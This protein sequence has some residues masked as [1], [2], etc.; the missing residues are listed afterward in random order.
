M[1]SCTYDRIVVVRTMRCLRNCDMCKCT[2]SVFTFQ[3]TLV[4]VSY[5]WLYWRQ[6]ACYI[7]SQIDVFLVRFVFILLPCRWVCE[8]A[9]AKLVCSF[10]K[11][12]N[13]SDKNCGYMNCSRK[14]IE[15]FSRYL[16][17]YDSIKCFVTEFSAVPPLR[18]TWRYSTR[19]PWHEYCLRI[20]GSNI[21]LS[22]LCFLV[23]IF[24]LWSPIP[25]L[26]GDALV[27]T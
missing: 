26:C 17:F 4:F 21:S 3:I 5:V 18:Q 8:L 9:C 7:W 6:D 19:S 27:Y 20:S 1:K 12:T 16:P 10:N 15:I 13:R 22:F 11:N 23:E 25:K 24:D 14:F 2:V